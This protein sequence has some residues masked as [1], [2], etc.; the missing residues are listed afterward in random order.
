MSTDNINTNHGPLQQQPAWNNFTKI[1][2]RILF[3]YFFVQAVPL[4]WKFYRDVF[5]FNWLQIRF[6]DIFNIAHYAPR[7]SSGL[8]TYADWGIILLLAVLGAIL[9]TYS[10]R[11]KK[12]DYNGL[13]YWLRVIVRY[14]LAIGII[15]YGF[16]KFFPIQ[17][18]YPSLSNLNTSYGDFTRWKLFSLSLGIV[19]GYET[20]LGTVEIVAGL[21]L[22]YRKTAS[23]GA[24]IVIIFTGNVFMSNLAYEGGEQVY[25]LYLITLA[26]FVLS[27]DTG[28]LTNLLVFQKPAK[29]G[30]FKPLFATRTQRNTAFAIKIIVVLFFVVL[31][32]FK[33]GTAYYKAA[34][35]FPEEQG[36]AGATGIY[37]VSSFRI[38]KD[39]LSYS[40]NN[41][42]R[43]KDVVFEKWN[44]LSIRSNRPVI[45]DSNN[46]EKIVTG[47]EAKYY[48][49][50]GSAARHYYSYVTDS[51]HHTLFL[52][53]KNK[54]YQEETLVFH[55]Q[56]AG[57]SALVL[58][59][60]NERKDSV[61][62][63][64][65]KIK[66]KYLLEEVAKR[67][68]QQPIKL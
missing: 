17:A 7:F 52:R 45:I 68:R 9:W 67:G 15:A 36:L 4:H 66:K 63:I 42:V 31:Y 47:K 56:Q 32:G 24:F 19:P 37:N 53:N 43:W 10:E 60:I 44:T 65:N 59:G 46:I 55:Y 38:N 13:Y 49:L 40:A 39:S 61:F 27:F 30:Y 29:P 12:N 21:L 48:E 25:S 1:V 33:T 62:V 16:I 8:Q 26:L 58:S 6:T 18:P 22:L 64:L 50:E 23:I 35:R 2:F 14:R 20:F 51:T 3:I 34:Y 41:P 54:H 11:N 28:R 5:S 57:D